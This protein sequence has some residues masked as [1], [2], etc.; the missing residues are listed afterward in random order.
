[1]Y[2]RAEIPMA[3]IAAE[4]PTEQRRAFIRKTYAHLGG[5]VL[6][7]AGVEFLLFATGAAET[8]AA[9][10]LAS[11]WGWLLVLGLFMG[12]GWVADKWARNLASVPMQYAGLG[13]YV[14]AEAIIFAPLLY[15][16]ALYSSPDVIPTAGLITAIVFAG[17]T[18]VVTLSGKDFSGLRS[19]LAIG[20]LAAMGLVVASI[21]FGL[22]LGTWFAA[23]M[24]VLASSYIVYYTSNILRSY[25]IGAHVAAALTLFAAVALLFYYVIILLMNNRD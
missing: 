15:L 12:V 13:L 14:I 17:L 22:S 16:A 3:R 23:G 9:T 6:A 7:F 2:S 10:L 24:V 21:V 4:A 5:A 11:R 20:G 1:M 19:Y 8:I 25:P 18:A